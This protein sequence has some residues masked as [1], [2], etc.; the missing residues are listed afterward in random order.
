[1]KAEMTLAIWNGHHAISRIP[2]TNGT[3]ARNGPKKRPMKIAAMPYFAMNACPRQQIGMARERPHPAD[4]RFKG[5]AQP[6]REPVPKR[7]ANGRRDPDWNKTE[8]ASADQSPDGHQRGRGR[9]QQ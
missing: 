6:I 7:C 9:K 5:L 3:A 1:M 8:R 4:R 2:A